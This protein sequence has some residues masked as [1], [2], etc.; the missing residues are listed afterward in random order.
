MLKRT[1]TGDIRAYIEIPPGFE[2]A[3]AS[4]GGEG[5]QTNILLDV[6]YDESDMTVSSDIISTLN[7]VTRNFAHIVIP[8]SI[9]THPVNVQSKI[10]QIDF[11]A[12]GIIVFG[13]LIMIPTSARIMTRDKEK[14]Y[15][16]RLLT[17]P[18]HPW[19]FIT[20]IPSAFAHR[21]R[22][23]FFFILFGWWFGMDIVGNLALAFLIF[24]LTA[25]SS[26]GIGMVVAALSKSENQAEPLTWIVAMPMAALSG[27]WFSST[28]MPEY[29]QTIGRL[30]PFAHAAEASRAVITRGAGLAAVQGDVIFLAAWA[31]GSILVG[32]F[33]FGRTMR[34]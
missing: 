27:V 6:T 10:T 4:V 3:V 29:M 32:I 17:T 21:Y 34:A 1:Q 33:L 14:G 15:L 23:I 22:Q 16:A 19:E 8:I 5:P 13:L 20:A 11:L 18:T 9:S 25:L 24:L 7:A 2:S 12:P 30:F 26:I 31:A 28:Y